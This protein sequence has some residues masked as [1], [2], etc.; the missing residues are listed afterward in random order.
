MFK[1]EGTP[2]RA[3]VPF[4]N[5]LLDCRFQPGQAAPTAD[6]NLIAHELTHVVN[7]GTTVRAWHLVKNR[8]PQGARPMHPAFSA[9][10]R[11][12]QFLPEIDDE[13]LVSFQ[14]GTPRATAIVFNPTELTIHKTV[15]WQNQQPAGGAGDVGMIRE[16][17]YRL[18][19]QQRTGIQPLTI[20]LMVATDSRTMRDAQ[21][22]RLI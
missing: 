16:G 22:F 10:G 5:W 1:A 18:V 19:V 13:V 4:Q 11:T 8:M 15:P 3:V 6:R 20:A 12:A 21:L 7:Q 2:V 17:N 9:A 14:N